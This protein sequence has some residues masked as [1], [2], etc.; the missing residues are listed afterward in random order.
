[1][2]ITALC[3]ESFKQTVRKFFKNT[4]ELTLSINFLEKIKDNKY[5][6]CWH[7]EQFEKLDKAKE[8]L[9]WYKLILE[10]GSSNV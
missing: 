5:T 3:D 6:I 9:K 1:M 10:E 2:E 4:K 7:E 8:V